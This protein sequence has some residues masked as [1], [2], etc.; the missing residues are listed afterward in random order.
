MQNFLNKIALDKIKA[1]LI[2]LDNT[3]CD[4]E[5]YYSYALERCYFK[6]NKEIKN[7]TFKEFEL[8]Y[9]NAQKILKENTYGQAS[10]H[11]RLI[12]FQLIFEKYFGKTCIDLAL[13]Y[14][15]LYY[16]SVFSKTK[17]Y[18]GVNEFLTELKKMNIKVCIVTDQVAELQ[19]KKIKI[20]KIDKLISFVVT[21]EEA[22]IE[23][24]SPKIFKIA[25]SKLGL[26]PS[27]VAVLGDSLKRDMQ[28]A[29]NA[30]IKHFYLL[31][32]EK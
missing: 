4:T 15:K 7:I 9:K 22:G 21:S 18:P 31:N 11:S 14:N 10:S 29:A 32:H 27:E 24:P 6:F 2:D 1:V 25:L 30:G 19:F 3:L 23:K 17:L 26:K 5:D 8:K 13:E 28:G 16:Q 20:L 12:Y